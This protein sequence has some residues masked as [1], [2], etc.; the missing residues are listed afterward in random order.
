MG[1][2]SLVLPVKVISDGPIY[3]LYFAARWWQASRIFLIPTPFGENAAPYFPAIGDLWHTWLFVA[4]GGDRL[5]RVG[6]IPFLILSAAVVYGLARRLRA[7]PSAAAVGASYFAS[8]SPLLVFSVEP[9]VDTIFIAG[10]LLAFYFAVRFALDD[11]GVGSLA[12]A[13]IAAGA[14]WGT[15]APGIVFVPP[16]IVAIAG[17]A[18]A[19]PGPLRRR[20][21]DAAVV[22]ATPFLLEGYW[23]WRNAWLTGN[24]LYPLHFTAFGHVLLAG[25]Y[26][27]GAME[28]SNYYAA[29]TDW[30]V[31]IDIIV[32]VFDPRLIPFWIAGLAGAWRIG[33]D[34][35]PEDQ[36][37]W[38]CSLFALLNIALYWLVIPYRSQQRFMLHATALA[39]VPLSLL[40]DR[41]RWIRA[42]GVLLLAVHVLTSQNWPVVATRGPAALGSEP[43]GPELGAAACSLPPRFRRPHE[44]SAGVEPIRGGHVAPHRRRLRRGGLVDGLG[45]AADRGGGGS[46]PS[47]WPA[48][49]CSSRAW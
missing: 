47:A 33:R 49:S 39:A 45:A 15:K 18:L 5:A 20:L 46:P 43:R 30:R 28:S 24:P 7:S 21:R 29:L 1:V 48:S 34:K 40:F 41:W 11:D 9:V 10:Y 27:P 3:H 36:V 2:S 25:W 26:G 4:W 8:V 35:A 12:L 6:Q 16:L 38:A 19:K 13:G 22:L 32:A 42:L 31:F 23:L 37:V 17:L 44:P 14:A